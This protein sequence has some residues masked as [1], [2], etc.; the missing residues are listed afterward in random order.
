MLSFAYRWLGEKTTHV[1]ALP[2]YPSYD[3]D[4]QCDRNL[5]HDLW[6]LLEAADITIAHNGDRHDIKKANAR[7]IY[8][9]FPPPSPSKSIDTFKEAKKRF[10]FSAN[11]LGHLGVYLGLGDKIKTTGFDLSRRCIAGDLSAW[12]ELKRYN[13]RDVDLLHAIFLRMRPYM[14]SHPNLNFYTRGD[15]CPVCQSPNVQAR[16]FNYSRTGKR[17]RI[18]CKDCGAWSAAG[19]LIK[20]AA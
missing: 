20:L 17:Q 11:N 19:P 9:G 12:A 10:K 18:Q 4:R 13:R 1:R 5:L 14:A 3:K 15:G 8:H 16:G 7:L 2:D 6:K